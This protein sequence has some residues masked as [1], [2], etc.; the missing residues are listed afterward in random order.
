MS[1]SK[2]TS[3]LGVTTSLANTDRLVV[4]TNPSGSAQ[5]QTVAVSTL[6]SKVTGQVSFSNTLMSVNTDLTIRAG[7]QTWNFSSNGLLTFPDGSYQG[8]AINLLNVTSDIVPA[9]DNTYSLG[10]SSHQWQS[11]YVTSNTIYISGTPLSI[12]N[13]NLTVNGAV[14]GTPAML[15]PN[16]AYTGVFNGYPA[17]LPVTRGQGVFFTSNNY[18]LETT[19]KYWLAT[20]FDTNDYDLSGTETID[21][22]N[23]GGIQSNFRLGGKSEVLLTD[24]NLHDINIVTD[25]FY[26]R[27]L[28]ALQTFN[29]NNLSYVGNYFQ[30]DNMDNA[31]T[32]F[33]FSNL[34][35]INGTFYYTWNDILENTPQF[36]ALETINNNMYI[37]YNNAIQNTMTFDSLRYVDYAAI[38]Q[39][40]GMVDGP[41][42][43]SL[44]SMGYL[45]M[46]NND[47]MT[48]PPQFPAL[49]TV[50]GSFYFYGHDS[51]T[52]APALPLLT[53]CGSI[54]IY[55]NQ[56]LDGGFD[57]T[58]LT[59]VTS[60]LNISDNIAMLTAP[61]FPALVEVNGALLIENN[62]SLV[63][64]FSF[65]SLKRV[66]GNVA[67]SNSALDEASVDYILT[68][69]ASLDGTAGTTS[70]DNRV[71]NL[72]G[73]SNAA[74][75]AAGLAAKA[76]LEG[77][78]NTV[79]VN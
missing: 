11:L 78:G 71:I 4:L 35:T 1:G 8:T 7:I 23:I 48:N 28:P 2:R 63:N 20:R 24:V 40:A 76:I 36:P 38:Y 18:T 43:P 10:N 19:D 33:D 26:L 13:G 56:M 77:R 54:Q 17:S 47:Y 65:P 67:M 25:Y 58:S 46:N 74:P 9:T 55:Q 32:Q 41:V 61:A 6:S 73:G 62:S 12:S 22:I 3:Q 50:N 69:L 52:T 59:H 5:T 37:Y 30:I 27:D 57:F 34:K 51:V 70:Y 72:S 64:G 60:T 53:T 49:L 16:I 14:V 75:G 79:Y 68:L 66:D 44:T 31:N 21:L 15:S 29:A 42:F 45:D 39:N